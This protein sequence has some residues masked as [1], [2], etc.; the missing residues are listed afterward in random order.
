MLVDQSVLSRAQTL[1]W[2]KELGSK[3]VAFSAYLAPLTS[4]E[5]VKK[6]LYSVLDRGGFLDG[7]SKKASGSPTGAAV[8]YLQ[9]E[10][11]VI[12][13]P[14]PLAES[15]LHTGFEP[16]PLRQMLEHDWM[17]GLVLVRLGH[18][19]IGLFKGETLLEG[20]AGTGLVHSRHHKGG[21]SAQRFER[22]RAKQMEFFF[23]RIQ[24]HA[25]EMLEPRL[26]E[27]DYI[28]YGGARDTLLRMWKQCRF[29]DGLAG[30]RVDRLLTVREA[31]RSAFDEAIAQAYD[32][33]L[34][35]LGE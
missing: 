19:A 20:K 3:P 23:T 21:S 24:Q 27:I 1:K 31:R 25:R 13:P 10:A 7:L 4:E 8:F 34:F 30:K 17:L 29:F 5:G 18:Y 33:R 32:C 35:T 11:R 15:G 16:A 28:F 2:L 14:F 12:L 9:D 22:H 6:L 26:K